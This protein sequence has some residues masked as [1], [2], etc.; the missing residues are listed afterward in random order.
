VDLALH[1]DLPGRFGGVVAVATSML[2]E[3]PES[4]VASKETPIFVTHGEQDDRVSVIIATQHVER[5]RKLEVNVTFKVYP[6]K[7]HQFI[8]SPQEARDVFEFLSSILHLRNLALENNPDIVP[9]A[10]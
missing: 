4:P 2:S 10:S 1:H 8:S 6:K 3:M 9:I 5:L 7:T